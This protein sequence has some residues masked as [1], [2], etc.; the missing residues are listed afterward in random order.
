MLNNIETK[1]DLMLNE[2]IDAISKIKSD[3]FFFNEFMKIIE[4]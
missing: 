4:I 2:N 3:Q 1:W